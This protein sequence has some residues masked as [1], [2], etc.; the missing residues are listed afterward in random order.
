MIALALG[1]GEGA[2]PMNEL[3]S[4]FNSPDFATIFMIE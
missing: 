4:S 2:T 3:I 1:F